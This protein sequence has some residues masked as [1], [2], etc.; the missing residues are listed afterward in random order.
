MRETYEG[1]Y[2]NFH[3][4]PDFSGGKVKIVNWKDGG[5]IEILITDVMGF[6]AEVVIPYLIHVNPPDYFKVKAQ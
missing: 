6:V 5:E 1:T 2:A 4:N 3:Y